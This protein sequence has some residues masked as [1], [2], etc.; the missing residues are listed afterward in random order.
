MK[1]IFSGSHLLITTFSCVT[2]LKI[3]KFTVINLL[4][5]LF[6]T[7]GRPRCCAH[8]ERWQFVTKRRIWCISSQ[9]TFQGLQTAG[10]GYSVGGWQ[11]KA[12]WLPSSKAFCAQTVQK[13]GRKIVLPLE[14]WATALPA[15]GSDS[16]SRTLGTDYSRSQIENF[17]KKRKCLE[18]SWIQPEELSKKENF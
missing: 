6:E 9:F 2:S 12:V 8:P 5:P 10:L 7:Q 15:H 13:Q 4:C 14:S 17:Q 18:T 11:R 3:L 16:Q 1:A